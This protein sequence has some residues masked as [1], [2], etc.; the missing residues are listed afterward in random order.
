VTSIA[1]RA[2]EHGSAV[3]KSIDAGIARRRRRER[4]LERRHR[5]EIVGEGASGSAR[6]ETVE[7]GAR[8]CGIAWH[9][10][11]GVH[12]RSAGR[13]IDAGEVIGGIGAVV[14][15]VVRAR[16]ALEDHAEVQVL[17]D[18]EQRLAR[19]CADGGIEDAHVVVDRA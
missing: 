10:H 11:D 15:A 2:R 4:V 14:G 13:G 8:A 3:A 9:R 12:P 1:P 18:A 19:V 6:D 5:I 17:L 16:C 7:R